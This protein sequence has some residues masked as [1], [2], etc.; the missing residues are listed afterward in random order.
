MFFITE[1]DDPFP[2]LEKTTMTQ[3]LSGKIE[4]VH[5][6]P[7]RKPYCQPHLYPHFFLSFF[8]LIFFCVLRLHLQHM[9][10]LRLGIELKLQL[11]PYATATAV[12]DPSCVCDLHHR[13]Q[14]SL[15]SLTHWIL[16]PLS[17]A[18]DQTHNLIVPSQIH[19]HCATTGT[20]ILFFFKIPKEVDSSPASEKS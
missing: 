3:G 1:F 14:T 20:T 6:F 15:R 8:F 13:W 11:P 10:I 7:C 9:K 5:S 18:R 16:N 4:D 17:K 2:R 12:R 19:F